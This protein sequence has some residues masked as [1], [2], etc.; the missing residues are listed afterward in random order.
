M[1]GP[2]VDSRA[3]NAHLSYER[4]LA[5][6]TLSCILLD[7]V[8]SHSEDDIYSLKLRVVWPAIEQIFSKIRQYVNGFIFS[9]VK[10]NLSVHWV[11]N[12]MYSHVHIIDRKNR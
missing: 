9:G 2:K 1:A 3:L 12:N 6:F 10:C 7:S 8:A 5:F 11:Y 4:L